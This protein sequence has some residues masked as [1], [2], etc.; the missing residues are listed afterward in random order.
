MANDYD[1][2][3]NVKT[4]NAKKAIQDEALRIATAKEIDAATS[5]RKQLEDA[6]QKADMDAFAKLKKEGSTY[7]KDGREITPWDKLMEKTEQVLHSE[8]HAYNDWRSAMM[9]LLSLYAMFVDAA[10]H[11]LEVLMSPLTIAI[12][13]GLRDKGLIPLKDKV[14][15]F[16]RG[17]HRV[18][19]PALVQN[20]TLSDDN[21]LDFGTLNRANDGIALEGTSTE[22]FR[23][24]VTLWLNDV[25]YEPANEEG[26]YV[27]KDEPRTILT[28]ERFNELKSSDVNGLNKFL[29]ESIELEVKSS[30]SP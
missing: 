17:D 23:T 6:R 3:R 27:T 7:D 24:L 19:L 18:D 25:G 8:Q 15:D 26:M 5:Y 4:A 28:K 11:S 16:I 20:V 21:K 30:P 13:Q 29:E 12:K 10:H 1:D 2:E 9:S 14:M 22:G